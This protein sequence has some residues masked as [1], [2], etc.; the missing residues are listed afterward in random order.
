MAFGEGHYRW[1]GSCSR[2]LLSRCEKWRRL[3]HRWVIKWA[4]YADWKRPSK[5]AVLMA[6][7]L[8]GTAFALLT[9]LNFWLH[10]LTFAMKMSTSQHRT[11]GL[12][13]LRLAVAK[14]DLA[15]WRGISRGPFRATQ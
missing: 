5:V 14:P 6:E 13:G 8:C 2:W 10:C 7:T 11:A 1:L 12:V 15:G 9:L 4:E 3:V